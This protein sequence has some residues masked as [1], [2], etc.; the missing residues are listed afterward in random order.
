MEGLN[1]A[2]Y[3]HNIIIVFCYLLRGNDVLLIRRGG[4]PYKGEVTIPGGKKEKGESPF[5]ACRREVLEETG[6]HVDDLDLAGI[7]SN[8]RCG[9]SADI[10]SFYFLSRS[11]HGEL[12]SGPEG[13]VAWHDVDDSFLIENV[14]PFYSLITPMALG[15]GKLFHGK[16]DVGEDG[17]I[18]GSDL[19]LTG[20][21]RK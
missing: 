6:L 17:S 21:I 1:E 11:F 8:C 16:I 12:H 3:G 13:T 14:S 7:V 18:L 2:K 4:M 9:G 19:S 20:G 5:E 15:E 10:T